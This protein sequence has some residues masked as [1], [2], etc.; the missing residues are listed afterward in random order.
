M[1]HFNTG[2]EHYLLIMHYLIMHY[3]LLMQYLLIMNI[4]QVS[5]A[6]EAIAFKLEL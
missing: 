2:S 1:V 3:L 5:A 6:C 4:N